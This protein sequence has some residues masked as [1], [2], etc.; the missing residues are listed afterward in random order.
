MSWNM[1]LIGS[2][3][4]NIM[5][6]ILKNGREENVFFKKYIGSASF[7]ISFDF[8]MVFFFP[9]RKKDGRIAR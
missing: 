9:H 7:D 4:C 6:Q 3:L 8:T 1:S 2:G 5:A